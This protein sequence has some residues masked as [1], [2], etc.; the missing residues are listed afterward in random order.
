MTQGRLNGADNEEFVLVSHPVHAKGLK[1]TENDYARD[2]TT[3]FTREIYYKGF[4]HLSLSL[5]SRIDS[6]DIY[7]SFIPTRLK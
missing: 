2:I 1:Y 3:V 5:S 7:F 4:Y 6:K